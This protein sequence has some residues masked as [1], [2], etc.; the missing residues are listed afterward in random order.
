MKFRKVILSFAMAMAVFASYMQ[1]R[2]VNI[3]QVPADEID[4]VYNQSVDSNQWISWPKGPQI[5]SEAGIVM[6]ADS[7]AILYAK[8][9]DNPHYPASI[10]KM[11]TG[12]VAIENNELTKM[13]TVTPDDYNF[14]KSGDNHIF[15]PAVRKKLP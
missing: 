10:T 11:L 9:I 8:N 4:G 2:A 6:D 7:G 12:L 5:Y 13:V 1:V 14:L 15:V 3:V